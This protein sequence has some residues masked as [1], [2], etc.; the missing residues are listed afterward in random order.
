MPQTQN[1]RTA[2]ISSFSGLRLLLLLNYFLDI[3]G[4][5]NRLLEDLT[6]DRPVQIILFPRL[7]PNM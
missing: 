1:K 2:K 3:R 4:Q 5:N 6:A 7:L